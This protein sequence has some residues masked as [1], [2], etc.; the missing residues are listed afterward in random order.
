M[1]AFDY[2]QD[3]CASLITAPPGPPTTGL[4]LTV[5]TGEG[6][7]FPDPALV[8]PYTCVICAPG[9]QPTLAN[10]EEVRVTAKAGDVFTLGAR[11]QGPTAARAVVAGDRFYLGAIAK[12]MLD[13]QALTTALTPGGR[14]TL[15]SGLPITLADVL[16]A[17]TLFY[18]AYGLGQIALY[19]GTRWISVTFSEISIA[20]PAVAAQMY[21]A[22]VYDN[23]GVPALE[24]VAWTSDLVRAIALARQD[25]IYCKAGALTRRYVGSFRTTASGQTE[26]SI[27]KRL[28]WNYY[29]RVPR[30]ARATDFTDTWTYNTPAW[31]QANAS[32]A[33][34]IAFVVGVQ[35]VEIDIK[36]VAAATNPGGICYCG[37]A[38]GKDSTNTAAIPFSLV[39]MVAANAFVQPMAVCTDVPA[40]GYH[41][42]AWLE[43]SNA[44]GVTT[45]C[46][47]NGGG[48][49]G[50]VTGIVGRVL[51]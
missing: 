8:G 2:A 18:T 15:T 23:G 35:E 21:D 12:Y 46:G 37:V 1:Y 47:D 3:Y 24:L 32:P 33:N 34:Q 38:V 20:V 29:N 50:P 51:G 44:V 27:A 13:L 36:V 31:R 7:L 19:N 11:A 4:S 48:S 6:S 28:L 25:G 26:D 39:S 49:A 43:I 5:T 22:F 40:P 41:F 16:A 10:A 30:V 45:W 14:L 9:V 42:Y 17:P